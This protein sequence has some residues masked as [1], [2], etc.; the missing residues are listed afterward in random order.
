MEANRVYYGELASLQ[1]GEDPYMFLKWEKQ[2][3]TMDN[4]K[5]EMLAKLH[6]HEALQ[7][8]QQIYAWTGT[9]AELQQVIGHDADLKDG[10]TYALI[11]QKEQP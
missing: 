10:I 8:D 1:E 3:N 9:R 4:Q 11:L 2:M 5:L 7:M 6:L